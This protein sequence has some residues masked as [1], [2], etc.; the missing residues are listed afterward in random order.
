MNQKY[1]RTKSIISFIIGLLLLVPILIILSFFAIFIRLESPGPVIYK[2]E[3][4]GLNGKAFTIYK[5]RSMINTAEDA[6]ATWAETDDPRI[7]KLGKFLRKTRIDELPQ[8]FNLLKGD[9]NIIG[10]R[11]ERAIF[12]QEFLKEIPDFN[13][14]LAVKPG[15]TGL[16]QVNGGYD[17]SPKEKL[18]YDKEY[19]QNYNLKTDLKIAL[20]TVRVILTGHGSR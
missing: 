17:L 2:Q 5:L 14:R 8:V 19:I 10:P 20:K 7:T 18:Y 11:P 12:I 4:I 16:A 3:R 6:G 13:D 1:M 15:I 9:M